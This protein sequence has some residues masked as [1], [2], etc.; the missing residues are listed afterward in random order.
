MSGPLSGMK[1]IELGGIGPAPFAAMALSDA[2]ADV[3]RIDREVDPAQQSDPV[4][5]G[6]NL[7]VMNR[8]RRSIVVDLKRPDAAE[9]I[10]T[11]VERADAVIEGFRPGVT[12]R[13]GIGPEACAERNPR[14]VYGRVTGW[15]R[16]GPYAM[17]AGHDIDY[18][19]MSGTLGAIGP[20]GG[21][22][23]PPLNL[24][25]DFG[26]GGLLLAYGMTCALLEVA[27]SGRGQTVDT[28]MV[29]GAA[30]LAT[31]IHGMRAKGLWGDER[32]SNIYDG[33]A[34]FYNIY[35]TSDARYVAVGA[36]EP[37]FFR[38]LL[39][40]LGLLDRFEV[41]A[42]FP[43]DARRWADLHEALTEKFLTRTRDEWESLL[44]GTNAC[45]SPVLSMDEAPKHEHLREWGT[46]VEY[47]GIIQPAP[48]PRFSRTPGAISRP[49]PLPGQGGLGALK[50]W[51]LEA[52][53]I[54]DL[55][56]SQVIGATE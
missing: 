31:Y 3:I 34:P 23:E 51:G 47:D 50:D 5:M 18:I 30:Y 45:V 48:A 28:A 24:L 22:P 14:L 4:Q 55:V 43:G 17:A 46:F 38:E 35:E 41:G 33:G 27:R 32:G 21:P 49:A 6:R 36:V 53:Q 29:D 42:P 40:L 16:V 15:G 44:A 26:G 52:D 10:L 13:L 56:A 1:V 12:E 25:G 11:L 2:G 8:G 54:E 39:E 7:N 37:Q 9:F 20:A 19:A